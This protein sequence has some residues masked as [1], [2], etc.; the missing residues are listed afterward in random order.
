MAI[1]YDPPFLIV[2]LSIFFPITYP[3][4]QNQDNKYNN[5][6]QNNENKLWAPKQDSGEGLGA[7]ESGSE[8]LI[9][10]YVNH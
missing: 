4:L 6:F 3:I 8:V 5:S 2:S 10:P 9:C 1:Y 7:R